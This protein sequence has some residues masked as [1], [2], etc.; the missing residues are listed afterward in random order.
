MGLYSQKLLRIVARIIINETVELECTAS[1]KM[2]KR[3]LNRPKQT[4]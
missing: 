2:R 3:F 1:D 4:G